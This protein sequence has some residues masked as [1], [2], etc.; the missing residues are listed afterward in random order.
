VAAPGRRRG[1]IAH[2][3]ER[4]ASGML[5]VSRQP[6]SGDPAQLNPFVVNTV[7]IVNVVKQEDVN[8]VKNPWFYDLRHSRRSRYSRHLRNQKS[9]S[10]SQLIL[11][12]APSIRI[13]NDHRPLV[14]A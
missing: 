11:Y 12:H 14:P 1:R 7:N 10:E 9:L 8:A 4:A 2:Q 13:R 3:I 5:A 6:D